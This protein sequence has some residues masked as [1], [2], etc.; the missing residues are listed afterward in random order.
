MNLDEQLLAKKQ[1]A[2]ETDE[3]SGASDRV[4][5]LREAQRAGAQDR[6]GSQSAMSLR[7]AVLAEKKKEAAKSIGAEEAAGEAGAS[8]LSLGTSRLLQQSWLN[9]IPSWGLTLIWVN[10]HVFL[11]Y[12]LGERLFCK[13]GEEWASMIPGSAAGAAGAAAG[14]KPPVK[15]SNECCL[16]A[17][18]DLGCLFVIIAV[19]SVIAMIVGAITSPLEA[20][21]ASLGAIWGAIAGI[22]N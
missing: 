10:I 9:L 22:S 14:A 21:K 11:S 5:G 6:A 13:L 1:E 20:L 4:G 17:G 15:A 19:G 8:P 18:C 2:A 12:V 3:L 16:L 7:E